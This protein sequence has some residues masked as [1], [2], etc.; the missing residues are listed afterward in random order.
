[1]P[2]ATQLTLIL[3]SFMLALAMAF[4]VIVIWYDV[5]RLVN[6]LFAIFLILVQVWNFGYLLS[7]VAIL[8]ETSP[9]LANTA[10]SLST[11]GFVGASISLWALVM[12]LVGIQPKR[13]RAWFVFYLTV[14]L[15]YALT[16]GRTTNDVLT[17]TPQIQTFILFFFGIFDALT[18]YIVWRYRRK[19]TSLVLIFGVLLFIGGQSIN[20]L[21][22]ELGIVS[23][24]TTISSVGALIIS[25]VVVQREIIRPLLERGS[26]LESMHH[27]SLAIT[28]RIA[29]D[30]VLGEIAA[31]AAQWLEADAAGIFLKQG[32]Q[33][34]LGAIYELPPDVHHHRLA[35]GQGI[36]GTVAQTKK[37]IYLE[38]YRRDW[39]GDE[40]LPLAFNTF[41]SVI[42]VPLI[43]DNAVIGVLMVIASAHGHLFDQED[44][45]LLELLASQAAVAIAYGDLFSEQKKLTEQLALAHEQ[46]RTVITGTESPVLAVDR[47]LN[48]IFTNPAAEEI[49]ALSTIHSRDSVLQA[50]PSHALPQDFKQVLRQITRNRAYRYEIEHEGKTY[51]CHVASLGNGRIEG[52][53]AVLNDITELKELDRIK[54]EMV[55]M[56]S[57]DLKNPLQAAMANLELLQEDTEALDDPEIDLS[58]GNI[59]RQLSKMYRIIGN[60]LDLERVRLGS[61]P[62]EICHPARIVTEAIDELQDMA[63]EENVAL[64]VEIAPDAADFLGDSDQVHRA[65]VNLIENAIKFNRSGGQVDVSVTMH[66][67]H[68]RFTVADTGIGIPPDMQSKI[69]D[70]FYRGH[71]SGA[72]HVSGSGLGL[73]LVKAVVDSHNGELTV[74][75]RPE[76]GTCF[77]IEI[78]SI[79]VVTQA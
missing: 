33:L 28:S 35:L 53:V 3:N 58:V 76:Q 19:F 70:R 67:N 27:V 49:F 26:Q 18:L 2:Y 5:R 40:D 9:V 22:P 55:R 42:C 10:F 15:G 24:S 77:Y 20:F 65:I 34:H 30:A 1:M 68:V 45:D 6:Q 16:L 63:H 41:G 23:I 75:S 57:H 50:I 11:A 46:L 78:P 69:F 74:D 54:S 43:Y 64:N 38:N 79:N 51:L 73:S 21:N 61:Q 13:F 71:Q 44:A 52:F 39:N 72:E 17:D 7:E 62:T 37:T 48:L 14:T 47:H 60:I 59:E 32:D 4:L 56:T 31:R 8:L 12:V 29:T 36:A 66:A 25:F